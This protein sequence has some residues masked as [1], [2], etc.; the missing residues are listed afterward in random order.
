MIYTDPNFGSVFFMSKFIPD[1]RFGLLFVVFGFIINR[2]I[3]HCAGDNVTDISIDFSKSIFK[4]A[5][6][7]PNW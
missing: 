1:P 7:C 6:P 2:M 5:I 3:P 4:E